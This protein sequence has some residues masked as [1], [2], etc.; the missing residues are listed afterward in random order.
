MPKAASSAH[1]T[2][3]TLRA[4]GV[5]ILAGSLHA[6]AS[7]AASAT[8]L[9]DETQSSFTGA[10]DVLADIT[11]TFLGSSTKETFAD[12]VAVDG[13][14]SGFAVADARPASNELV[15]EDVFLTALVDASLSDSVTILG[16]AV[17]L[18]AELT[19]VSLQLDE[20]T[21]AAL[22]AGT[23]A[24]SY[25]WSA[26]LPVT[27]TVQYVYAISLDGDDLATVED[28]WVDTL[29][30]SLSGTWSTDA[31]GSRLSYMASSPPLTVPISESLSSGPVDVSLDGTAAL[32]DLAIDVVAVPEPSALALHLAALGGV[33]ALAAIR[34]RAAT[35]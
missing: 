27:A 13:P 30:L 15:F 17:G 5:L 20:H 10:A 25:D 4:C 9:V 8:Y 33:V 28:E 7:S 23:P 11:L 35:V 31:Q 22:V 18:R 6:N 16:F 34:R 24:G 26:L 3:R 21:T 29:T 19:T 12:M 14:I 2:R 1:R 32:S